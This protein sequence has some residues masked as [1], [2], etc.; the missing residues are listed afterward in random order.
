MKE[1]V[2]AARVELRG[3]GL[4]ESPHCYKRLPEVLAA[5]AGSIRIVHT[6][7]PLGVAMASA[8]EFDPYKDQTLLRFFVLPFLV[9]DAKFETQGIKP[10]K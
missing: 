8:E 4:D 10:F 5:H 2:K 3:A 7:T 9:L 6:L 1:G